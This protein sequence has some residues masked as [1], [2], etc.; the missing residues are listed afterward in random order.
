M[1]I[2]ERR[3]NSPLPRVLEAPKRK[4]LVLGYAQVIYIGSFTI[5][6]GNPEILF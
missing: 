3:T 2:P 6:T 5:P 1:R 4:Q